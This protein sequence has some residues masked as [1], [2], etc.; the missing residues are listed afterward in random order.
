MIVV[1]SRVAALKEFTEGYHGRKLS[2]KLTKAETEYLVKFCED[3]ANLGHLEFEYAVNRAQL[4]TES[5]PKHWALMAEILV[6]AN[7]RAFRPRT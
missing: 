3:H 6:S 1:V 5:K 7:S 4:G 2:S